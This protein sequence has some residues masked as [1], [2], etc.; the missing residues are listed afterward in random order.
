M[1]EAFSAAS[2]AVSLMKEAMTLLDAPEA[3]RAAQ[4]L[5]LAI[6]AVSGVAFTTTDAAE[7]PPSS[8]IDER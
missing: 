1:T 8:R 2:I 5:R 4:L 6:E 7:V 3:A